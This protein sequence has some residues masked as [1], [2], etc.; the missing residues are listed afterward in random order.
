MR[1]QKGL[2]LV[3]VLGSIVLLGIAILSLTYILQQAT[4]H[5]K[6]NEK[7]DQSVQ[8]TRTVIEEL[9]K[10]LKDS[11]KTSITVYNQP[12]S[13]DNLRSSSLASTTN[14]YYP[15]ATAPQYEIS[16][17]VSS[18]GLGKVTVDGTVPTD[19]DNIFKR[20]DII[21]TNLNSSKTYK[22]ESFIE[23]T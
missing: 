1:N 22:L 2:T 9:K 10:N 4:L 12:I 13:L 19:L 21:C 8:L 18:S 15:N 7:V 20:I 17:Q 11:S 3:E 6:D 14:I 5:T 16:I 23:Y